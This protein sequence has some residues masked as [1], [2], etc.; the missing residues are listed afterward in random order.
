MRRRL[1]APEHP[2][3]VHFRTLPAEMQRGC[4]ATMLERA[5]RFLLSFATVPSII[6]RSRSVYR[7]ARIIHPHRTNTSD[8]RRPAAMVDA[9][10]CADASIN[11]MSGPNNNA[12]HRYRIAMR[13]RLEERTSECLQPMPRYEHTFSIRCKKRNGRAPAAVLVSGCRMSA[14]HRPLP[15]QCA[16]GVSSA[17]RPAFSLRSPSRSARRGGDPLFFRSVH[18]LTHRAFVIR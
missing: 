14:T 1:W 5:W 9:T 2:R 12:P 16:G 11:R 7:A 6:Y 4:T 15:V 10:I 18:A 17:D 3:C 8:L 13:A